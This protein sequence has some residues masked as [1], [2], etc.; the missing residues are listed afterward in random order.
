MAVHTRVSKKHPDLAILHSTC[1]ATILTRHP[2]RLLALLE[3]PGFIEDHRRVWIAHG[4][5]QIGA[6]IIADGFRIPACPSQQMLETI[7][8]RIPID[9]CQ[10]PAVFALHRTEQTPDIGPCV[11]TGFAPREVRHEPPFYL[12]QPEAPFT[13]RLQRQVAW[14]WALLLSRLHSSIP[15]QGVWKQDTIRSTTVVLVCALTSRPASKPGC[16]RT[17]PLW[18]KLC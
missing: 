6:Q 16:N 15:P 3:K 8:R 17:W 2:N 14:R 7:G 18:E 11:V 1:G 9:F 12:G 4:L 5:D 13:Y 10:L